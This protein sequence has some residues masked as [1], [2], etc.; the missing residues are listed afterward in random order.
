M[1]GAAVAA[2]PIVHAM[3][4]AFS[5]TTVSLQLPAHFILDRLWREDDVPGLALPA[6]AVVH[7]VGDDLTS[8]WY[9]HIGPL[10]AVAPVRVAGVTSEEVLFVM[11]RLAW[12]H[13]LRVIYRMTLPSAE[14]ESDGDQTR[15]TLVSWIVAP[16]LEIA[17]SAI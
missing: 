6:G 5:A 7:R 2:C 16:R 14:L 4:K 1:L 8:I 11:E 3:S 9:E 10:W 12:D 13:G 17:A 15:H